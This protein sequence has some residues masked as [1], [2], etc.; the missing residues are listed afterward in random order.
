MAIAKINK[1]K[2]QKLNVII[3]LKKQNSRNTG[4][5]I[6]VILIVIKH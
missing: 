3:R 2:Q 1:K 5:V 4:K 6:I